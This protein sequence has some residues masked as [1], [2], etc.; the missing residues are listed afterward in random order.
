MEATVH[1]VLTMTI[2]SQ[3]IITQATFITPPLGAPMGHHL[4]PRVTMDSIL[5]ALHIQQAFLKVALAP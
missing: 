5:L 2:T 1:M 4:V 3:D